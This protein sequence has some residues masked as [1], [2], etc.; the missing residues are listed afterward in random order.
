[1]SGLMNLLLASNRRGTLDSGNC[2]EKSKEDED[3]EKN[4]KKSPAASQILNQVPS[5]PPQS[6]YM[7][8]LVI[9]QEQ[10]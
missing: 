8:L 1:M 5:I 6:S 9:K 4:W 7:R 2:Y 10:A 3:E